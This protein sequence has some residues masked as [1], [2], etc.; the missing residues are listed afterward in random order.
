M[1]N[2]QEQLLDEFFLT[3]DELARRWRYTPE[4]L[5]QQRGRGE[6]IPFLKLNGRVLYRASDVLA[7]ESKGIVET[8]SLSRV[9]RALS[10]VPGVPPAHVAKVR[11][12]LEKELAPG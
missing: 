4:Y 12:H 8:L 6:G 11:A 5:Q 1:A 9:V 3:T 10:D 2:L 7:A